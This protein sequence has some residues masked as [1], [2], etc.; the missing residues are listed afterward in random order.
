MWDFKS[1]FMSPQLSPLLSRADVD[2]ALIQLHGVKDEREN[3]GATK[4]RPK[5]CPRCQDLNPSIVTP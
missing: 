5:P 4:V 1:L 3:G 2:R